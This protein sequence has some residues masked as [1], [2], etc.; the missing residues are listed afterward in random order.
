MNRTSY[1]RVPQSEAEHN[2]NAHEVG[3]KVTNRTKKVDV[4]NHKRQHRNRVEQCSA[5][6]QAF[7]WVAVASIMVYSTDFLNTVVYD[8]RVA[9]GWFNLGLF[10][11]GIL[12]AMF[13]YAVIWLPCVKKIHYDIE[14][15]S[16]RFVPVAAVVLVTQGIW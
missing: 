3:S 7:L 10:C 9:R 4:E 14:V 11:F 15:V 6:V 16:P 13:F 2:A 5:K 8:E 12:M 1:S